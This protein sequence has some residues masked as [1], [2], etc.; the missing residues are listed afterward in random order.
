M[1]NDVLRGRA[2]DTLQQQQRLTIDELSRTVAV[3]DSVIE[4][5]DQLI[6]LLEY[7]LKN[8]QYDCDIDKRLN[9]EKLIR[10]RKRMLVLSGISVFELMLLLL[11][12]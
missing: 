1:V 6:S 8:Q 5:K 4:K 12:F 10:L 7:R 9:E 3:A 2:C 11:L